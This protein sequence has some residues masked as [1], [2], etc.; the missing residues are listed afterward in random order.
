VS[1]I[2]WH[3]GNTTV[4]TPYRL[5]EALQVLKNSEFHGNLVGTEREEGF[6]KL[7]NERS[8]VKAERI[9][10]SIGAD[11]SDL[12]RKWRSALG[13]LGFVVMHLKKGIKQGID[14][15]IEPFVTD[16]P[17]LTGRP[18]EITPNGHRLIDAD[19][20]AEQ[21][22]CFLR[23]LAAYKIPSIFEPRYRCSPFFPLRFVLQI[24][25]HLEES[26]EA[27]IIRFE[28]MALFVQRRTLDDGIDN[29]ISEILAYR[30]K[31]SESGNKKKFDR[32]RLL[33]AVGGDPSKAGTLND[34]S[35][36]NFR[37]LK[38]T[39]LFQSKGR[40]ITLLPEKHTLIELLVSE[41]D[42]LYNDSAYVRNLWSGGKLPTDDKIKAINI[43]HSLIN[44]LVNH[45]E[46]LDIPDINERFVPDL[47][48][49]RYKLEERL[50]HFKELAFAKEQADSWKEIVDFM[51][52]FRSSKRK[53]VFPSGETLKISSGDA[54]AYLE[55]IIWRAFLAIDSL[56]NK[57][58]DARKFKID[59]DFLPL[60]HAPG[61]GPD[62]VFEFEE[63][64]L[65]VEVTLTSSSRQE[66][67]EGEPVRRHVAKIAEHFENEDKKVYCLFIALHIDSNTAETFKSGNWYKKDNTKLP[68]QIVPVT[69]DDF[70][71]LFEIGFKF[72]NLDPMKIKQLLTECRALSNRDAPEWKKA[73][74]AEIK[75]FI[76]KL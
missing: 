11:F 66:A 31:K 21:Q 57:P 34:Y 7:L 74:S 65:V 35:D 38:A 12:G 32:S 54:P 14:P 59:Q 42:V 56:E 26:G 3:I 73:I 45:G 37:Y 44:Q 61:G 63:Y 17:N 47:S 76:S 48:Q 29:A 64:V 40:A 5:K 24:L 10:Q 55:W 52:V 71:H 46:K 43:I 8:I 16:F 67:T 51:K 49:I 36:L 20:A 2:L 15:E 18:Y 75:K 4:R 19:S 1:S 6:A 69:L 60:S 70:I 25:L 68:L 72:G 22:E 30:K 23:A 41:D 9:S 33:E 27:P 62:M 13:Q 28:E 53:I 58:W 39:G 50:L